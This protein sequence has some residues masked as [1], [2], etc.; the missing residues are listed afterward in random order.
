MRS[1]GK[2]RNHEFTCVFLQPLVTRAMNI[3]WTFKVLKPAV[4]QPPAGYSA[5]PSAV[6]QIICKYIMEIYELLFH[7][8]KV[9]YKKCILR[10]CVLQVG[11]LSLGY[12]KVNMQL[13][14]PLV[15]DQLLNAVKETLQKAQPSLEPIRPITPLATTKE[16]EFQV[17]CY[18][19]LADVTTWLD[20]LLIK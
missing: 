5:N 19:M 11:M 10:S 20:L 8:V 14:S 16:M 3:V 17:Y 13:A 6:H 12:P 7:L 1:L 15:H 2:L 18:T 4:V 9:I